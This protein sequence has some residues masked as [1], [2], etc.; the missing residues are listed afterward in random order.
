MESGAVRVTLP[1]VQKVVGPLAVIVGFAGAL[2]T[3]TVVA[4]LATEVQPPAF[5]TWTVNE[6]EF[7]T[8]ID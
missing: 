7:V 2:V 5:V 3:V 8:L 1:P 6:P 4:S